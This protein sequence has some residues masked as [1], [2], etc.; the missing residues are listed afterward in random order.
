VLG[1]RRFVLNICIITSSFPSHCDDIVQAP[2]LIDFIE[3]LKKRG[4]RVFVFTQDR[5]GEKNEFIK[6]IK[7]K[8]FPWVKSEK[9][10]VQLNPFNPFDFF[11]ILSLLLNGKREVVPFFAQNN[12]EACLALWVLPNGY[13]AHRAFRQTQIPYSLWSL[14]SDI[15]RYGRHPLL[16]PVMK[17]IIQDAKGVFADGFDLSKRVEE[18]FGR[19]CF[20]LATTRVLER[21]EP[22]E[23]NK[24]NGP[25][26]PGKPYRFL[27]VGRIEKVKG[28]DLLLQAMAYLKEELPN[29]HLTVVGRGGMEKWSRNFIQE[30][31]LGGYVSW[32]GC[33]SDQTLVSLYDASD[34]VVIPSRS[35]SIPLVFSVALRVDKD[36]IVTDVGD[37]G[38]LGHRY[39]VAWVIPPED[40]MALKEIMKKRAQLHEDESENKEEGKR[41]ELMRLFDIEMSVERFLADYR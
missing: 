2:F 26:K 22:N 9:P 12:I 13:F 37:M 20:F 31:T 7:I 25:D 19:K 30:K 3:G 33:V 28:I 36:L 34:C 41:K 40:V 16:Y 38:M 32:M 11:R 8:W 24:L 18:R 23:P 5:Q 35:E 27:F 4:H 15:Y 1:Y 29:V 39:G 10:L 21:I 17:R 14:G 6:D